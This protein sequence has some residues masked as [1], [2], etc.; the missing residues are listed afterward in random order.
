MNT[1]EHGFKHQEIKRKIIGTFYA[2]YN[3]LGHG[4]LESVYQASLVI[5]LKAEGL[6]VCTP[7][8]IS[9]WFRGN[10]VGKIEEDVLVSDRETPEI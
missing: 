7:I 5:A 9:V 2:V 1:N 6:K 10:N 3:E 8:E 4:F